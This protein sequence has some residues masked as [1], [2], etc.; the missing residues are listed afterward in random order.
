MGLLLAWFDPFSSSVGCLLQGALSRA[1]FDTASCTNVAA[2]LPTAPTT[3]WAYT[4]P[5]ITGTVTWGTGG[6]GIPSVA[7]GGLTAALEMK[8]SH[9]VE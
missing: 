7:N 4:V 3:L 9:D 8:V 2:V 5:N 6:A 1:L